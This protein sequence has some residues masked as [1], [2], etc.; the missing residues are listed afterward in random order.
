MPANSAVRTATTAS[1][2][3]AQSRAYA[4]SAWT[5]TSADPVKAARLALAI[6]TRNS[7][8]GRPR[9]S[10][11]SAVRPASPDDCSGLAIE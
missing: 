7:A 6:I 11:Y 1:A 8:K 9:P 2:N 4:A 10:T 3:A 5:R